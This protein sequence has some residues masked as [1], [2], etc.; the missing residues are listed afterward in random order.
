ML[1]ILEI[2]DNC[3]FLVNIGEVFFVLFK[4]FVIFR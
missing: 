1:L 4:G 3:L 2:H